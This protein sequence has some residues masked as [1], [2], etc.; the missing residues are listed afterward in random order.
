GSTGAVEGAGR[1]LV[2][3]VERPGGDLV[4][5][6]EG[7]RGHLV[8]AGE[9]AGREPVAGRGV[10]HSLLGSRRP[11]RP[12]GRGAPR[13]PKRL[14]GRGGAGWASSFSTHRGRRVFAPGR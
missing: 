2:V 8:V 13:V 12:A 9:G 1:H 4:V 6:V 14:P 10:H 11:C 7:A 3:A 5:A